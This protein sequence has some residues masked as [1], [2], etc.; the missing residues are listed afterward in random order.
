MVAG[1]L[2]ASGPSDGPQE[3]A[4]DNDAAGEERRTHQDAPERPGDAGEYRRGRR[5]QWVPAPEFIFIGLQIRLRSSPRGDQGF[6]REPSRFHCRL[7]AFAALRIRE[8]GRVAG[9]HDPIAN[10][11]PRAGAGGEVGMAVPL[12]ER[13]AAGESALL[14][15]RLEVV[16]VG[17]EVAVLAATEPDVEMAALADAPAV[18]FEIAAEE[19]L[20]SLTVR[21]AVVVFEPE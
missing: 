4:I 7:D 14:E 19:Q 12:D 1:G 21:G 10:Q 15:E 5:R 16:D 3:P 13:G 17:I 18:A 2:Q 20:G 8:T 6:R 11:R 9:E